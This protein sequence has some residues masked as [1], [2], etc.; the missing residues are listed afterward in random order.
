[1]IRR[2]L[3]PGFQVP[4]TTVAD[5]DGKTALFLS[6]LGTGVDKKGNP[7]RIIEVALLQ[8]GKNHCFSLEALVS[9]LLGS[10][11]T[12]ATAAMSVKKF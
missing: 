12:V 1:M 6:Q 5:C 10:N 2:K 9:A 7:C 4:L 11:P 3:P 8:D